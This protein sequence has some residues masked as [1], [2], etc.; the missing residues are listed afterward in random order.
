MLCQVEQYDVPFEPSECLH[1]IELTTVCERRV[2]DTI[3]VIA[4]IFDSSRYLPAVQTTAQGCSDTC[5]GCG[6][7]H[8]S[9]GQANVR[10]STAELVFKVNQ[11]S[12]YYM[13]HDTREHTP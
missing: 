5:C 11:G 10:I 7:E 13:G 6:P 4:I 3:S 9:E 2:T 1:G 8:P 12:Q